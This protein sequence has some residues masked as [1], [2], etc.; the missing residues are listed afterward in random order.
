M[1]ADLITGLSPPGLPDSKPEP[2]LRF[3]EKARNR[4]K[5][6]DPECGFF[7]AKI[8]II[9]DQI[10]RK[11]RMTKPT[12]LSKLRGFRSFNSPSQGWCRT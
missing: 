6:D 5:H 4:F 1:G 7:F 8:L 3:Q 2:G 10:L 12:P 11:L 9:G